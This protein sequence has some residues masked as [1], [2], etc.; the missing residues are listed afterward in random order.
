MRVIETCKLWFSSEFVIPNSYSKDLQSPAMKVFSPTQ[1]IDKMEVILMLLKKLPQ[2][3][4]GRHGRLLSTQNILDEHGT[5][6]AIEFSN[7]CVDACA[8]SKDW[9]H[10]KF[11][12][13]LDN[14]FFCLPA[15]ALPNNSFQPVFLN[16]C[17]WICKGEL[18]GSKSVIE[19][20][21]MFC[22]AS[23]AA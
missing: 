3:D 5:T 13:K 10:F 21:S 9:N 11:F 18:N 2:K 1:K 20:R 23:G 15:C 8:I 7:R 14:P 4:S 6:W 22:K 12:T 19:Q 17:F 16:S